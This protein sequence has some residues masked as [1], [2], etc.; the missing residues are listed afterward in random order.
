MRPGVADGSVCVDDREVQAMIHAP[1]GW[2]GPLLG[3]QHGDRGL[4]LAHGVHVSMTRCCR[5]PESDRPLPRR[6]ARL[7]QDQTQAG[8]G[9]LAAARIR[10]AAM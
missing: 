3:S 7:M 6:F 5:F 9:W 8:Y 4:P 2:G 10:M 1:P